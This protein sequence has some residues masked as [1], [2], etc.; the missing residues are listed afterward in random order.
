[1]AGFSHRKKILFIGG[2]A[3]VFCLLAFFVFLPR[4]RGRTHKEFSLSGPV[5][6]ERHCASC[7]GAG[8][9]GG[10]DIPNLKISELKLD[11]FAALVMG[12]KGKMP[13]FFGILYDSDLEPLFRTIREKP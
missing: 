2:P 6:Y 11:A 10:K 4:T 3:L 9:E 13:A 12:G 7:H 5:L 1:M 8:A